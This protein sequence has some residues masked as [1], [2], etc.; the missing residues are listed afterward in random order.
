MYSFS[1][2][3]PVCSSMSSYNCCFLTC[4]Q[5]SQGWVKWSGI[6]I[7]LRISH[8]LL[9]FTQRF[10]HSKTEV[11]VF[12]KP[13]CFLYD[14]ADVANLLSGF[15]AFSKSSLNIW[16]FTVH[17]LLNPDME[18]FEHYFAS[19][20]DECNCVV[21]WT[22]FGIAILWD[23]NENFFQSCGHCWVF[24][25]CCRTE[26]NTFTASSFRFWTSS[27]GILWPPLAALFIV[28]LAMAHLTSHSRITGSRWVMKPSW[29]SGSWSYFS[30]S[31]PV[32]CCHLFL[33]SSASV[34]SILFLS[35]IVPIFSWNVP[36][37][38]N[39]LE[40]ISSLS[41]S[42]V[43]ISLHWPLRKAFL[44][45]L[46]LLWNSAF[47]WVYFSFSLSP[48][49]SLLFSAICKASSD[50][51][52]AFLHFFSLGMAESEEE[53]KSLLRKVKE[54]SE[55]VDLRLNI[56]KAKIMSSSPITSWQIVGET[57]ET[58]TDFFFMGSKI[59]PDADCSHERH[60]DTC[61]LEEK[62]WQT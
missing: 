33:I 52:F 32:Y 8:S 2:L 1:Y 14:P 18:N 59:T 17:A 7:S 60:K 13:F 51:N 49:I 25:I 22:F 62:L 34:R 5:I 21:V 58:G 9:W 54:E 47:K 42:I 44:S 16:K 3:E 37:V 4:I 19:M 48:L 40:E 12:L 10:W 15:S 11:A 57:M 46:A 55:K 29:L 56:Q 50:N 23:W 53:L 26:W 45:L 27:T 61:S 31:P 28:M 6:P 30:H 39:F 36:F 43:S 35:F 38:S 20:W 41:H 24:Q